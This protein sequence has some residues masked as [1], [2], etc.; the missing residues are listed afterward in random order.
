MCI[1]NTSKRKLTSLPKQ[2]YS[3]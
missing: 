1:Y 3:I 2:K